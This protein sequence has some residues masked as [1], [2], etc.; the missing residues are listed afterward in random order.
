MTWNIIK[1]SSRP[2]LRMAKGL[3][4]RTWDL[5]PR[6]VLD[7]SVMRRLG[8]LI[9]DYHTKHKDRAQTHFTQFMR[10]VPLLTVLAR[11][12]AEYFPEG[13]TVRLASIGCSTG[14][15]LYSVVSV[16]RAARPDIDLIATGVDLSEAVVETAR[17][18]VYK[19]DVAAAEGG[20]FAAIRPEVSS[21]E[22]SDLTGLFNEL[23]DGS[24]SIKTSLRAGTSWLA[25]DATD[26]GLIELIGKHDIVIANNFLAPMDDATAQACLRNI[27]DLVNSR[28]ILVVDGVDLDIKTDALASTDFNPV[29]DDLEAIWSGDDSKSGWP[30]VRWAREPIDPRRR[31]MDIRYSTIF[32]R[33]PSVFEDG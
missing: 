27:L 29:T 5:L 11:L 23:P 2:F 15:E 18:G 16:L 3:A 7:T 24:L 14:A 31:D 9:F 20:M 13:A 32:T 17:T 25:A 4:Q 30:W 1:T 33:G 28:G 26:P 6:Y 8:H 19:A 21:V 12:V 10:N 22:L